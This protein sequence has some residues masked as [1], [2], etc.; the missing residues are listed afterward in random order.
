MTSFEICN[1]EEFVAEATP[2]PGS[3]IEAAS[4]QEILIQQIEGYLSR[5]NAAVCTDV[6]ALQTTIT[7]LT[8][9]VAALNCPPPNGGGGLPDLDDLVEVSSGR[10]IN[11]SPSFFKLIDVGALPNTANKAIAH[12]IVPAAP[13]TDFVVVSMTGG[14]NDLVAA[15]FN[16]PLLWTAVSAFPATNNVSLYTDVTNL[17]VTTGRDQT[18]YTDCYVILEYFYQ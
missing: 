16:L 7:E 12:G 15:K 17:N 13:F 6:S 14:A 5:L 2:Q 1:F 4:T 9:T 8:A 11:G 18:A 10:E 3:L